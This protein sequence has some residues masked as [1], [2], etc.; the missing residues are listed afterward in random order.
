MMGSFDPISEFVLL[1][2]LF[3]LLLLETGKAFSD[4]NE[5]LQ[6]YIIHLDHSQKPDSFSTNHEWHR[7]ILTSLSNP[8]PDDDDN[9]AILY[10]YEHVLHGFSARLTKS[11]LSEIQ[12]S[13][14][15]IATHKDSF[16]KLATTHSPQFL[17][18]NHK[19][20]LWPI[21]SYGAGAIIGVVDTGIWPESESFNDDGMPP[22]PERWKG[23]CENGESF[24]PSLCNRKLIG[25][26]SFSKGLVGEGSKVNPEVDYDSARDFSGHGTHVSSTAAGNYVNGV[27]YFGYALGKARGVAP[28]A[29]IASY[30]ALHSTSSGEYGSAVDVLAAI[31]AAITD[32]VDILSMSIGYNPDYY[33]NDP[34]AIGS[35]KAIE[36]GIFVVSA[37]GNND[38]Y[39]STS[40]FNRTQNGAPWITTIGAATIDRSFKAVLKLKNGKPLKGISYFPQSIFISNTSLY[41]G[42]SSEAESKCSPGSLNPSEAHR[43]IVVCNVS[44]FMTISMKGQEKE[45]VR[46][47]AEAGIFV[48]EKLGITGPSKFYT[49]P[50]MMVPASSFKDLV[51]EQKVKSLKFVTTEY[52]TKPAPE[53]AEF[54]LRGPNQ[55]S[56]NILKPDIVAPGVDILAATVP[57][58]PVTTLGRYGL[59]TDYTIMSGTSMATPHVAGVAAML[60]N[61]HP[62]W[63]PA[64]IRSAI[65]TTS[66][67]IDNTG[68]FLL[69]QLTKMS[70]TPLACGAG[71]IDPNKAIDP[72]LV[73]DLSFHDYV[74]FLCGLGYSRKE[75]EIVIGKRHWNCRRGKEQDLNYPS[76]MAIFSGEQRSPAVKKFSRVVTNVGNDSSVYHATTEYAIPGFSIVV[77][78]STLSFT[79]KYQKR[80]FSMEIK[81]NEEV[82]TE[83]QAEFYG[84]L[85]W[86]DQHNHVVS[87]PVE[88]LKL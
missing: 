44:S 26:R 41:F 28:R 31:D 76:F 19:N 84:F 6:T 12:N 67:V 8:P 69:D 62:E 56:P 42:R 52:H 61:V 79:H 40:P 24:S 73:Y 2:L 46:V 83:K 23:Q 48:L 88:I 55:V 43:K 63:S 9:E 17:G 80:C 65:M 64:A 21:A 39:L 20:G 74:G 33:F 11:Q 72:G 54:S 66:Y 75:M 70:A 14:A 50:I 60:K 35:L 18:L 49:I 53:V 68:N 78:P 36:K 38:E 85:K 32:G 45:L 3:L 16:V 29:H 7:S 34:I 1:C 4:Q 81:L 57:T 27:S 58:V 82:L 13:P 30:K 47:G 51:S 77:E 87:S 15:H 37:A 5:Q 71:H 22:V 10:S 59:T 25:A 86:T